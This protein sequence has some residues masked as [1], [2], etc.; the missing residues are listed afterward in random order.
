MQFFKLLPSV[1]IARDNIEMNAVVCEPF[2]KIG[3]NRTK[4]CLFIKL[5][6][7]INVFFKRYCTETS[8]HGFNFNRR[9]MCDIF[10]SC[11]KN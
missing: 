7:H 3:P 1:D 2:Q 9:L 4:P 6:H 11:P 8:S 5:Y 10:D